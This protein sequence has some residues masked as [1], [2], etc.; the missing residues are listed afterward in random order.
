MSINAA[1]GIAEGAVVFGGCR[2]VW[3][4]ECELMAVEV[5]AQGFGVMVDVEVTHNDPGVGEVGE[6]GGRA[7]ELSGT[8]QQL[9][10]DLVH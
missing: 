9:L 5:S 8:L 2:I 6:G 3:G 10:V 4:G 1:W 7:E